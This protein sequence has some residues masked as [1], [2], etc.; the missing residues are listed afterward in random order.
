MTP[1]RQRLVDDLR[2]RNYSPRTVQ[3]YVHAVAR[4]ARHFG[5][6]PEH[7][8]PDDIR[9]YQLH[10]IDQEHASWSRF[11]QAVCA[12]R[13]LYRVTLGRPE[14]IPMIP[15]GKRPRTLPSVLSP[16]EVLHLFAALPE[17]PL[18]QLVRT[19]YACGLRIS[20]VVRL[21]VTDIDS[22]RGVLV[23]RQG[24]GRKDRL[25]PLSPVLLAELRAYWR[26][27]RP[28]VWLFPGQ[29]RG[30]PL[31][32]S[33]LQRKFARL[34]RP[35]G[36]TKAVSMHTLRHSYATHL[37]EAGVD[38]VTL[39]HLLG[40]RDLSTTARYLHVSTQQLRRT[41]SPLDALVA[42]P[43]TTAAAPILAAPAW[44]VEAP[45]PESQR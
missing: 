13:F 11:N 44:L 26:R 3:T 33:A 21:R 45:L 40:H 32:M 12:L 22:A 37:L 4:F 1:L 19:T 18:R 7:L 38:V 39:Q 28:A 15:F 43:A 30:Q 17:T 29:K 2:L 41:P 27:Y 8:G 24:K 6:S 42:R 35:L 31:N 23:V 34:V 20:E 36:F 16:D 10:L 25:V 5:R 9:A 14:L